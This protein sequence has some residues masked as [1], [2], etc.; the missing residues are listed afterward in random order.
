MNLKF[1]CTIGVLGSCGAGKSKL[2]KY[3]I[4]YYKSN[5][6]FVFVL[7]GTGFN[8]GYDFLKDI[9]MKHKV[10]NGLKFNDKLAFIMKKQKYYKENNIKSSVLIVFDDLMGQ[11]KKSKVIEQLIST[12]RH[13]NISI[14]FISQSA[15]GIA[16][17][18]R[19]LLYYACIFGQYTARSLKAIW[20][21]YF[22]DMS[23]K[24]LIDYMKGKLTRPYSF[25]LMDRIQKN[26]RIMIAPA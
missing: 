22:Q 11:V 14:I 8:R 13:F 24:E 18:L 26:K 21:S 25:I 1:P 10:M 17:D 4:T 20:E 6:D 5:F 9:G 3:I 2:C 7:T 12:F 15:F 19:E 23:Y 16:P